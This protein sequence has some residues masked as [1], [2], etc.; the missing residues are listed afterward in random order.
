M[1]NTHDVD[2]LDRILTPGYINHNPNVAAGRD[3]NRQFWS[4]L[5]ITMPDLSAAIDDRVVGRFTYRG[6]HTGGSRP[7]TTQTSGP[8]DRDAADQ[9]V[10]LTASPARDAR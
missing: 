1:L 7:P 4:G 6:T 10:P 5:F 9:P 3:T 8:E 2:V